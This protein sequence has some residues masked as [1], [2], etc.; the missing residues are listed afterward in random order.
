MKAPRTQLTVETLRTIVTEIIGYSL[1]DY[2]SFQFVCEF[3]VCESCQRIFA[4]YAREI[5]TYYSMCDYVAVTSLTEY[6][7]DREKYSSW[8]N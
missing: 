7:R 4:H 5:E 1:R 3:P 2:S 6:G 8:N